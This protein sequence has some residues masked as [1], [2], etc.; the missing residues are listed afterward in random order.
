MLRKGWC[1]MSEEAS[2]CGR[3]CVQGVSRL[4]G[5]VLQAQRD[6][7]TNKKEPKR[8][9]SNETSEK[10]LCEGK[11]NS[12]TRCK[13]KISTENQAGAHLMAR[14]DKGA[15]AC[16]LVPLSSKRCSTPRQKAYLQAGLGAACAVYAKLKTFSSFVVGPTFTT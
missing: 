14:P 13:W 12:H 15:D 2:R 11:E 7:T 5:S 4:Y 8:E 1:Q 3:V 9:S 10:R 16:C 6:Q